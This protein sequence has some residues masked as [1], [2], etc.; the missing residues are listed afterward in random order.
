MSMGDSAKLGYESAIINSQLVPVAPGQAYAP[1]T[2]GQV[3][4]GPGRWPRNGPYNIP[5]IVSTSAGQASNAGG[6]TTGM[7][8][9]PTSGAASANG[10]VNWFHPTKS[11]LLWAVGFLIAGLLMLHHIHFK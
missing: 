3:F 6:V 11:P 10:N 8:P 2:F 5:P 4:V 7:Q 9:V 1:L